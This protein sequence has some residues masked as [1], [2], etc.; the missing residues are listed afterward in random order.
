M[1]IEGLT[2]ATQTR[3]AAEALAGKVGRVVEG[4]AYGLDEQGELIGD[5][6]F[7]TLK[8][9]WADILVRIGIAK[10]GNLGGRFVA[11][12]VGQDNFNL[13]TKFNANPKEFSDN[14]I[15]NAVKCLSRS[16][17]SAV[18]SDFDLLSAV[19]AELGR[20]DGKF[21]GWVKLSDFAPGRNG[22]AGRLLEMHRTLHEVVIPQRLQAR[23]RVLDQVK[24]GE[25]TAAMRG[26]GVAN[27]PEKTAPDGRPVVEQRKIY[28]DELRAAAWAIRAGSE[29]PGMASGVGDL[30]EQDGEVTQLLK[31]TSGR[32]GRATARANTILTEFNVACRH[33]RAEFPQ[34][35]SEQAN[36]LVQKFREDYVAV[37]ESEF[38]RLD[39][40]DGAR[41]R[42][43]GER[44]AP[45]HDAGTQEGDL[46]AVERDPFVAREP[47]FYRA[48][49]KKPD[50]ANL[51]AGDWKAALRHM[52]TD[53]ETMQTMQKWATKPDGPRVS[54]G[55]EAREE[56]EVRRSI[57]DPPNVS[58]PRPAF[59][60][61]TPMRLGDV[62]AE[63]NGKLAHIKDLFE[64]EDVLNF[65]QLVEFAKDLRAIY[66]SAE[67]LLHEKQEAAA[68][69][70][71][72]NF[73]Q[74]VE[75]ISEVLPILDSL[76]TSAPDRV[77]DVLSEFGWLMKATAERDL[78]VAQNR[79]EHP[80]APENADYF[81][82]FA[83]AYTMT[84]RDPDGGPGDYEGVP[85]TDFNTGEP[86]D[87]RAEALSEAQS[88][89]RAAQRVIERL[90]QIEAFF[91]AP[92]AESD[93]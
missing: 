5:A 73:A 53:T 61:D 24:Q 25:P 46:E 35:T 42:Q 37:L 48:A 23:Q 45:I 57:A 21:K 83:E 14:S 19:D 8:G 32:H 74:H 65:H 92:V 93:K 11:A 27:W 43:D 12:L 58:A 67:V 81:Q 18:E 33:I 39:S 68:L 20:K 15:L 51:E 63:A 62:A 16:E 50:E 55:G 34:P 72:P 49:V 60:G 29:D 90:D 10:P 75:T 40:E 22:N 85:V 80:N 4:K 76:K 91:K 47:I 17:K 28:P 7:S 31:D 82:Q 59:P 84:V 52:D 6:L 2:D 69:A 87:A 30:R 36:A 70:G 56:F 41:V 54:F 38:N 1:T 9:K 3:Q 66:Q 89:A 26:E 44:S 88:V 86:Y 77:K 79:L 78:G 64:E 13:I 71:H